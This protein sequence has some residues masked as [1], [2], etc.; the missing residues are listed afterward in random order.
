MALK[1]YMV[2][3]HGYRYRYMVQVHGYRYMVQVQVHGYRYMVR[4]MGTGTTREQ[5]R[6]SGTWY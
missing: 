2:Q 1:W 5:V 6:C 3:V 4:Y